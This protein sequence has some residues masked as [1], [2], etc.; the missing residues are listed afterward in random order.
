[1]VFDQLVPAISGVD[2][3]KAT[4]LNACGLSVDD[5]LRRRYAKPKAAVLRFFPTVSGILTD[6][7]GFDKANSIVGIEA[8][9]FVKINHKMRTAMTD[10]D[11]LGYILAIGNDIVETQL[12][13]NQ[14]EKLINFEVIPHADH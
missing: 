4:V 3:A 11:R 6:I 10:G 2:V 7:S 8:K 12:K 9:P 13:A 14:A 5:I 1:M